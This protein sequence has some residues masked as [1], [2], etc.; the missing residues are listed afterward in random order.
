MDKLF[1]LSTKAGNGEF[2]EFSKEILKVYKDHNR[3]DE[4]HVLMTEY[5][6]HAKDAAREF[7]KE[8]PENK[9]LIACG[10]DG[11][12]NELANVLA[13]TKASLGLIPMGT[14]NDFSKN[15]DYSNFKIEDSFEPRIS[16]ID[17]IKVNDSLCINVLSL[18]FDTHILEKTYEL[19]EE[20]PKLKEKAFTKAVRQSIFKLEAED[21]ELDILDSNNEKKTI[22]GQFL[23]SAICNGGFYGS[24]FNPAPSSKIDDGLLNLILVDKMPLLRVLPLVLK[25]KKGTHINHPKVKEYLIKEGTIRS[26]KLLTANIDGEIFK[27]KEIKIKILEKAINFAYF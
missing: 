9:L 10:G 18:G 25:Y 20:D 27:A 11:T 22:K 2:D 15:F 24:G 6:D 17:L 21:L 7:I 1:I 23:I 3:Q 8:N 4:V 13:G 16:P 14:G 19:L 5:K 26:E 12:L